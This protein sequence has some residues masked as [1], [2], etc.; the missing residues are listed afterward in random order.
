[1]EDSRSEKAVKYKELSGKHGTKEYEM[2]FLKYVP[3]NNKNKNKSDDKTIVEEVIEE[4]KK[5]VKNKKKDRESSPLNKFFSR[6][7][8]KNRSNFLF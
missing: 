4:D 6:N 5:Q 8:K 3:H 1:L 7:T 2:W